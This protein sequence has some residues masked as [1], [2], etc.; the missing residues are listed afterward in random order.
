VV[1]IDADLTP[2]QALPVKEA[3][4]T[5]VTEGI[6]QIDQVIP[7]VVA[8][9]DD[10]QIRIAGKNFESED[11]RVQFEDLEA[12]AATLSDDDLLVTLPQGLL[13][14]VN[15]LKIL[16][17][18]TAAGSDNGNTVIRSN[19]AFFVL[20]P[21]LASDISF[22]TVADPRDANEASMDTI[23]IQPMPDVGPLQPAKLW[24][25]EKPSATSKGRAFG[26]VSLLRFSS[27]AKFSGELESQTLSRNFL[28]VF[29][30]Q[31]ITLSQN[32]SV[33]VKNSG[34]NWLISDSDNQQTYS[35]RR[36]TDRLYIYFGF[37]MTL[38]DM[39][40]SAA[41]KI[42]PGLPLAPGTYL[43]RLDVGDQQVIESQI[44][45]DRKSGQLSPVV[46]IL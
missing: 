6:P 44:H 25:N 20:Q 32:S 2:E 8:F 28:T 46:D 16:K 37:G 7:S 17:Q 34:T 45:T 41:F 12:V 23:I 39:T 30:N 40:H 15:Q 5:T 24:L 1:I 18:S 33:E 38:R 9:S 27:D 29:K 11:T 35:I 31:G 43:V 22:Q 13:G 10:A 42:T 26:L 14:G 36:L 19:S 21:R 3:K 4:I